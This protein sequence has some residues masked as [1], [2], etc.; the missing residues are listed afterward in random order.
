MFIISDL[1]AFVAGERHSCSITFP[2]VADKKCIS[3]VFDAVD[4]NPRKVLATSNNQHSDERGDN[5]KGETLTYR[6]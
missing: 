1:S 4:R 6:I 2:D 3:T 5:Q